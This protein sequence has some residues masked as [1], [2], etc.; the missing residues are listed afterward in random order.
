MREINKLLL[1]S[2]D[3][4]FRFPRRD[5][6]RSNYYSSVTPPGIGGIQQSVGWMRF[7]YPP[8]TLPRKGI[9]IIGLRKILARTYLQSRAGNK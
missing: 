1:P 5:D 3:A 4:E 7:A 2:L 8:Y 9:V 6:G